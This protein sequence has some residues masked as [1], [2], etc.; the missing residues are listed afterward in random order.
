[1]KR[2]SY[3]TL[4]CLIVI[5]VGIAY[6]AEPVSR[7]IEA[8]SR[9]AAPMASTT[10]TAAT[11][12]ALAAPSVLRSTDVALSQ[13]DAQP[14]TELKLLKSEVL[15]KSALATN[16]ANLKR[17]D[18]SI[19]LAS[20][21]LV[22][23]GFE[24]Q[25]K[26][27]NFLGLKETYEVTAKGTGEKTQETFTLVVQD[28]RSKTGKDLAALARV[29]VEAGDEKE[30]YTF[31]LIAPEGN[32][33]NAIEYKV[34]AAQVATPKLEVIR[35]A[36]PQLE[37]VKSN[38]WWSCVKYQIRKDC[39]TQ[40]KN[41]LTQCSGTWAQYLSCVAWRCGGCFVKKS[42]CC[43]CDCRWWCRWAVGCC[44]R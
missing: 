3:L 37:V 12:T 39:V 6:A 30:E 42:A 21:F 41:A 13:T 40:C 44:D 17:S 4:V 28:Y 25:T 35:A 38:S 14:E 20:D 23:E 18:R 29:T 10:P 7:S 27:E 33:D 43:A 9:E 24:A 19:A 16:F 36:T 5:L 22:K 31:N 1:M 32:F 8:V 34:A 11:S 26:D 2:N 15:A